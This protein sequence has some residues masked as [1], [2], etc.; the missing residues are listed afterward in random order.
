MVRVAG[1][2]TDNQ[3]WPHTQVVPSYTNVETEGQ[4]KKVTILSLT[5]V[6]RLSQKSNSQFSALSLV[7]K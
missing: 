5:P 3:H 2:M 7:S 1:K 4:K 6:P